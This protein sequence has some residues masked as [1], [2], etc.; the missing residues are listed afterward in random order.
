MSECSSLRKG[1]GGTVEKRSN[2][3]LLSAVEHF[4]TSPNW[5]PGARYA[6][7]HRMQ[8]YRRTVIAEARRRGLL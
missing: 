7:Q 2:S 1:F 6:R 5:Q 3:Q 8:L 4:K